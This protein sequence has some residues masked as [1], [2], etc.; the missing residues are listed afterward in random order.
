M[1]SDKYSFEFTKDEFNN[2]IY[3]AREAQIRFK[4]LRKAVDRG[5]ADVS[6]WTRDECNV[7]IQKWRN[8]EQALVRQYEAVV[9][10]A[11]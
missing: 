4:R 8:V 5:D 7:N 1:S 10:D 9:K 3:A 11:W 2:L 6:H